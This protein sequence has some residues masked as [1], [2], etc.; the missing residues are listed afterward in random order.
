V[1]A[2]RLHDSGTAILPQLAL[3][4][5]LRRGDYDRHLRQARRRYRRRRDALLAALER[6]LPEARP[7][8]IEAGLH[9]TVALPPEVDP[10]ALNAAAKRRRVGITTLDLYL[11]GAPT[12]DAEIVVGYANLPE[13]AA[14]PAVRLLAACVAESRSVR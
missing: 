5:L 8:G 2:K 10:V 3:A 7:D 1:T 12:G 4:E 9:V 13:A 6:H 14:D 11:L